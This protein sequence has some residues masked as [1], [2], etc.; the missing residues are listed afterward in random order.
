MRRPCRAQF[1]RAIIEAS[2]LPACNA[3]L[4]RVFTFDDSTRAPAAGAAAA[5]AAAAEGA[6]R[7]SDEALA[8]RVL[9]I[10]RSCTAYALAEPPLASLFPLLA[11]VLQRNSRARAAV[12]GMLESACHLPVEPLRMIDWRTVPVD[13]GATAHAAPATAEVSGGCAAAAA[14]V[15]SAEAPEA[16]AVAANEAAAEAAALAA[17]SETAAG[18]ELV[19]RLEKDHAQVTASRV[20][21]TSPAAIEAAAQARAQLKAAEVAAEAEVAAVEEAAQEAV[22]DEPDGPTSARWRFLSAYVPA[23]LAATRG[24][25]ESA[26]PT[27]ALRTS[28]AAAHLLASY[29]K[30]MSTLQSMMAL[31]LLP[32]LEQLATRVAVSPLRAGAPCTR[33]LACLE[34]AACASTTA[35]ATAIVSMEDLHAAIDCLLGHVRLL[36]QL[37]RGHRGLLAGWATPRGEG[38]DGLLWQLAAPLAAAVGRSRA[39]SGSAREALLASAGRLAYFACRLID[40]IDAI[41]GQDGGAV[42]GAPTGDASAADGSAASSVVSLA[43]CGASWLRAGDEVACRELLTS[44]GLGSR[45]LGRLLHGASGDG[46]VWL[47]AVELRSRLLPSLLKM[48]ELGA[49]AED[50]ARARCTQAAPAS[51]GA[52]RVESSSSALALPVDWMTLPCRSLGV[53]AADGTVDYA[54]LVAQ[55][56]AALQWLQLLL[57]H[58]PLC[59]VPRSRLLCRLIAV[60]TIPGAPWRDAVISASLRSL[61]M[62]LI[63]AR[64]TGGDGAGGVGLAAA[65]DALLASERAVDVRSLLD[66]VLTTYSAE[67]YGDENFTLW[68]LL[69]LRVGEPPSVALTIWAVL[70]ELSTTVLVARPPADMLHAWTVGVLGAPLVQGTAGAAP[71]TVA[72]EL[73]SAWEGSVLGGRL[74]RAAQ[75]SF[76]RELALHH[77]AARSLTA[78]GVPLLVRLL[79]GGVAAAELCRAAALGAEPGVA[80]EA[81]QRM[82]ALLE[83]EGEEAALARVRVV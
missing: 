8:S 83:Q 47:S 58:A 64:R 13:G 24:T 26:E 39:R 81:A 29:V 37:S 34:R 52:L 57:P 60:Y 51:L 15:A 82:R 53:V 63:G 78:S 10:W 71:P 12:F 21:A 19:A 11:S 54:E 50:Q 48:L 32:W 46:A 16:K 70:D 41:V 30:T 25:D 44:I 6:A 67:S 72:E 36:W 62:G 42:G 43:M 56:R 27:E 75:G 59:R 66:D 28:G 7:A 45:W 4:A 17:A 2:V 35:S 68:L 65:G 69:G 1:A 73:L 49:P 74:A 33:A 5:G 79:M 14:A 3:L 20:D 61:L 18:R 77:L 38:V 40:A 9:G 55:L 31:P 76:L 80:A 23:A 22:E